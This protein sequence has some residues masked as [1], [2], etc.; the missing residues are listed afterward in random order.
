MISLSPK[1]WIVSSGRPTWVRIAIL[2]AS[3]SSRM[4][5]CESTSLPWW[6]LTRIAH[7]FWRI[8]WRTTSGSSLAWRGLGRTAAL[9]YLPGESARALV[10]PL[11][12][13]LVVI[14]ALDQL[15]DVRLR[16]ADLRGSFLRIVPDR[17]AH[18][19]EEGLCFGRTV[20]VALDHHAHV[21]VD[22]TV[23][24]IPTHLGLAAAA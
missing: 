7:G 6:L 1:P 8:S 10:P 22:R 13:S 11:E 18:D 19:V 3:S 9:R 2:S 12:A 15:D 14:M 21:I 24:A 17:G 16:S 5:A 4:G 20:E 23:D